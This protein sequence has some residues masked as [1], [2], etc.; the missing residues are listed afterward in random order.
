MRKLIIDSRC[1]GVACLLAVAVSLVACG[2]SPSP[3]VPTPTAVADPADAREMTIDEMTAALEAWF[4]SRGS[5]PKNLEEM[6]KAGFIKKLPTPPA[7][8][9][10]AIDAKN[11]KVVLVDRLLG[12]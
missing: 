5:A 6:V 1:L 3:P 11:L 2:K 9:E 4:T 8:K 10:F 7:G 12:N